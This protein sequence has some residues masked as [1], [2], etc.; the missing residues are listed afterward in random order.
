M[1]ISSKLNENCVFYTKQTNAN[2][3]KRFYSV[4]FSKETGCAYFIPIDSFHSVAFLDEANRSMK[5]ID[6]QNLIFEDC[7]KM[8]H[9]SRNKHDQLCIEM[10]NYLYKPLKC[11]LNPDHVKRFLAELY[12]STG[13]RISHLSEN[14]NKNSEPQTGDP[15]DL[16]NC[17]HWHLIMVNLY[18]IRKIDILDLKV[19]VFLRKAQVLRFVEIE[20][21]LDDDRSKLLSVLQT[22]GHLIKGNWVIKSNLLYKFSALHDSEARQNHYKDLIAAREH[23][24]FLIATNRAITFADIY[25]KFKVGRGGGRKTK[26][27]N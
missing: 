13:K 5:S 2:L 18:D 20:Q 21:I 1:K 8:P 12:T 19:E 9:P 27:G 17:P 6:S 14:R 10:K 23:L 22:V 16:A 4:K 15:V 26:S 25:S 7:F 24:L 3:D 11:V